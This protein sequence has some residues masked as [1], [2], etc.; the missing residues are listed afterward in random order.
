M[1]LVELDE[2]GGLL[3]NIVGDPAAVKVGSPAEVVW[4]PGPPGRT[5]PRFVLAARPARDAD[6]RQVPICDRDSWC[7]HIFDRETG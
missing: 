6:A 1:A 7:I 5:V 4:Q 3:A 2:G